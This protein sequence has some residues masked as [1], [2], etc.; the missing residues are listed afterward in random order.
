MNMAAVKLG[1]GVWRVPTAGANLINSFLF[2]E[3][4]G[5][6]T[7]VDAGMKRAP[8]RLVRALTELGKR[9]QDVSRI[10]L[11]HAHRD[12]VGGASTMRTRT[13]ASVHSHNIDAKY[14]RDGRH[15]SLDREV[16]LAR[17]FAHITTRLPSCEVDE[18]FDDGDLLDVAGGVSVLHT[19]GHSPGHCSFLHKASGVLITGDALVN[20]RH[21]MS[22]SYAAFCSN[23]KLSQDTADRL[24]EPDYE[25]AAF[26][27]GP[28][29]RSGAREA[30][31]G[32]LTKR[33]NR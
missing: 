11:T 10:L 25:I 3:P 33:R 21:K 27:H 7:L 17:I 20:F 16:P 26:T 18:T 6:L 15:P 30:V 29:I 2:E 22:Y 13:G 12:H 5:S 4:D 23:F 14:I 1:E 32:F 8:R 28:E 9:P 31:R 24:G 19:P